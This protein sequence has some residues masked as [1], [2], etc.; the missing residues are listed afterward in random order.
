MC[1][2]VRMDYKVGFVMLPTL[3]YGEGWMDAHKYSSYQNLIQNHLTS[4]DCHGF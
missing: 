1:V 2:V 4:S 3:Q